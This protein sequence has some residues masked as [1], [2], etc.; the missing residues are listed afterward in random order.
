VIKDLA[1][2]YVEAKKLAAIF[3]KSPKNIYEYTDVYV[4]KYAQERANYLME[5]VKAGEP[6]KYDRIGDRS[7]A[8]VKAKLAADKWL[9][10][11]TSASERASHRLRIVLHGFHP[12]HSTLS[13]VYPAEN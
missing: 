1:N 6:L 13:N 10:D 8:M 3:H 12:D 11:N 7:S 4:A 9:T 2:A 5:A